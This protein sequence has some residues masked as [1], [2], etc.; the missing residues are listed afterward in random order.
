MRTTLA[1]DDDVISAVKNLA[2]LRRQSVGSIL[3][4]LHDKR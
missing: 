3:S 1:I 2:S 4:A